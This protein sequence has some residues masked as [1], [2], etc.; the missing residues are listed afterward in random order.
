MK[1]KKTKREI[2]IIFAVVGAI[3][4]Y[5]LYNP[6]AIKGL[7]PYFVGLGL[8]SLTNTP[9]VFRIWEDFV[10]VVLGKKIHTYK[11]NSF[12]YN[13][14]VF[15]LFST[16]TSV[17]LSHNSVAMKDPVYFTLQV[18]IFTIGYIFLGML[19]YHIGDAVVKIIKPHNR[20]Y[21]YL[22][23][24]MLICVISVIVLH[25]TYLYLGGIF[26]YPG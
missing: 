13:L 19:N 23:C 25:T 24:A 17:L 16:F 6:D 11:R 1:P 21:L 18:L 8:S 15:A 14:A 22:F 9:A 12:M 2:T 7:F 5:N 4:A 3:V 10:E 20:R 26:I